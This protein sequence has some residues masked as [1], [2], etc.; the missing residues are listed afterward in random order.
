MTEF[1]ESTEVDKQF[2]LLIISDSDQAKITPI[3]NNYLRTL[4][5]TTYDF[6]DTTQSAIYSVALN[7]CIYNKS[8]ERFELQRPDSDPDNSANLYTT[9]INNSYY[10]KMD[11]NSVDNG[12]Q[13]AQFT[14][15]DVQFKGPADTTRIAYHLYVPVLVKKLLQFEFNAS[16][17]SGTPYYPSACSVL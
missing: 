16:I 4:T 13:N 15:L 8:S 9:K 11:A 3:I 17:E 6:A 7:T 10:F 2:P 14:L 5:N 1:D 12:H